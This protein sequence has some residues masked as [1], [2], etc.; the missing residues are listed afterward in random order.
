MGRAAV[1]LALITSLV[2]SLTS[3][4]TPATGVVSGTVL[5]DTASPQPVR[6]A[7]VR[8]EGAG[9]G[10]RLVGTDGEGRFT[11]GGLRAGAYTLSASKPGLVTT[12]HGS[13]R[14]GRGPGVLVV[15]SDGARASVSLKM[16]PGAAITG[17]VTDTTGA[18]APAMPVI[19]VGVRG[20]TAVGP[21]ARTTTDDRGVYRIYGLAP[22]DYLVSVVPPAVVVRGSQIGA[23]AVT[24]NQEVEWARRALQT[25]AA[26]R[27][28]A[29]NAAVSS[30]RAVAYAPVYYPRTSDPSAAAPITLRGGEER[31]GVDLAVRVVPVS[32]LSGT[33]VDVSGA[34]VSPASVALYPR[35]RDV[36]TKADRLFASG[37]LQLPRTTVSGG[38][39]SATGVAPGEYT[40]V[41][42]S[43]S[44]QR[45]APVATSIIWSVTDIAVDGEDQANLQ[46]Q[47]LPGATL[48]GAII[49]ERSAGAV[50]PALTSIQLSLVAS[51]TSLGAASTPRAVVEA[52]GGFRFSSLAPARYTLR[53]S[54]P[55]ASATRWTVKS[56][57]LK[58]RDISDGQFEARP[59]G[60]LDGVVITLTDRP[61]E[62][63]GR[64]VDA[65]GG[66][67]THYS[68][69]VFSVDRA[70]WLPDS[71]RVRATPPSTDGSFSIIG[72][73]PG[74]YALAAAEQVEDLDVAD[75]A[76]LSRLLDSA[77]RFT[78][79]DGQRTRQDLRVGP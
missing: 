43:G 55:P 20:G 31:A 16:L 37:A 7:T 70:H 1:L 73:P 76:F 51:G 35:R 11:F 10:A 74:E 6:R 5:T 15:V 34:P 8:L 72:L 52:G 71:R 9:P 12:F 69:I 79:A 2:V 57:L 65:A 3:Q 61:T 22:G 53:A 59:G 48:S 21:P 75:P 49:L 13:R 67:T 78:L 63:S 27:A 36:A 17:T 45:G 42:R 54:L 19:A 28:P 38:A 40:L 46:L 26:G 50:P 58:G 33:L 23:I 77:Y 44:G 32:R 56:A 24:S 47:L 64:L 30:T 66:P 39:F 14:P 4:G 41:A 68:V 60:D 25:G 29:A 18:P 62:V